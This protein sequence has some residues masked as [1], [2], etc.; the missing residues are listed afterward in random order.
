VSAIAI[1][2]SRLPVMIDNRH[3]SPFPSVAPVE[4]IVLIIPAFNEE[5]FIGSVVLKALKQVENVIVVDDGST[6]ATAEIAASAGALV[7][8]HECNQ[9]KGAALNTGFQVARSL[10]PDAVVLIDGDG[11]HLPEEMPRVLGPILQGQADIVVGSRYLDDHSAVPRHRV[12]GHWGFNLITQLASGVPASDSQSGY[13][14]FSHQAVEQITFSSRGF[15]V[16]CEMQFLAH[17][18]GLIFSEVPITI[19]YQD[20]PKRNVFTHGLLVL[21]GLLRLISQHRPLFFFGIAGLLL[22]LVGLMWGLVILERF[23]QTR[24][25]AT[26]PAVMCILFSMS[27]LVFV[28]TGITLHSVRALLL[29]FTSAWRNHK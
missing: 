4:N 24:Q 14:A 23:T 25:L 12:L 20:K 18:L 19:R 16:E 2:F 27:G 22:F 10:A 21:N 7:V 13:R 8:K 5:R 11:Q 1:D 17:E 3:L 15:S 9:G 6:D 29:E 26:G 28:S